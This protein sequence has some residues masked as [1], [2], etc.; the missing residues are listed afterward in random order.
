[1]HSPTALMLQSCHVLL[2][3]AQF[4]GGVLQGPTHRAGCCRVSSAGLDT[5]VP[6]HQE[7]TAVT[8]HLQPRRHTGWPRH[9]ASGQCRELLQTPCH[10]D[11]PHGHPLLLP[12][13]SHWPSLSSAL[14]PKSS[15][16]SSHPC[17]GA[18]PAAS[19]A[20]HH[21]P[22]LVAWHPCSPTLGRSCPHRQGGSTPHPGIQCLELRSVVGNASQP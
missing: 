4:C 10:A 7:G 3:Q 8:P 16:C 2:V 17:C 20:A 5:Q 14:A 21:V 22:S 18:V 6:V 19:P 9:T 15:R 11:P 13:C 12:A 1:M